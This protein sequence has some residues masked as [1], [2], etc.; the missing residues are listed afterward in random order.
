M[1]SEKLN[2]KKIIVIGGGFSGLATAALLAKRGFEVTLF[3]KNSSLGGRARVLHKNQF[4]FDM[5]PSWYMMPEI[6]ERYFAQFNK[7]VSDFYQLVRLDPSYKIFFEDAESIVIPSN[8]SKVEKIFEEIETGAGEKFKTYLDKSHELYELATQELVYSDPS[9]FTTWLS[10]RRMFLACKF[11][12]KINILQTWS[13]KIQ[14]LFKDQKLFQ[15]LCFPAVFLGSSPYRMPSLFSI[16]S[17]ADFGKGIWYPKGGMIQVVRALE[18][19]AKENGV[20]IV[21]KAD[22]SKIEVER[23]RATGVIVNDKKYL[24]D[25]VVVATDIAHVEMQLIP[26]KYQT[27]PEKYWQKKSLA[28]SAVLIYLGLKKRVPD[29]VHHSLYFSKDWEQNFDDIFK[30]K[31]LPHQPSFYIST[32]SVTDRSIV[33]K[34]GEEL[35][36]LIPVP[37]QLGGSNTSYETLANETIKKIEQ[38]FNFSITDSIVVKELYTPDM[39]AQDYHSYQG[40]ALG[41]EHTLSQ[42]L[43]FRPGNKS[44]KIANLYY[45][46][47]YT[48]PGI[49]VPMALISAEI[50]TNRITHDEQKRHI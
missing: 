37:A 31:I 42:S 10:I 47:Q 26:P 38:L 18:T 8:I 34:N 23:G 36:V 32:R 1:R 29:A 5:G 30:R 12:L 25:V 35:F 6:F 2:M 3:E 49:G 41:L 48:N 21:L 15:I 13:Q 43:F 28:I 4:Q 19:L 22:V 20:S 45:A 16:L 33:P 9:D 7:K 27:Y 11:F 50:V 39:F 46:G 40:T 44:K 14:T 17:W 24:A